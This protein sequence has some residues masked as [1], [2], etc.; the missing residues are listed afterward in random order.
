MKANS[1]K[2]VFPR[3]TNKS[4][5]SSL[6][7]IDNTNILEVDTF[8]YLGVT[9]TKT[10]KWT[11]HIQN[12]CSKAYQKL[13][14]LYRKLRNAPSDVRL[15]AYNSLGRPKLEYACIIWDPHTAT[16]VNI[17]ENLQRKYVRFIF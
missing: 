11:N 7:T 6:Y 4:S 8:R 3:V 5:L 1:D 9:I 13:G 17:V 16:D 12:I 10:L 14:F 2:T 15:L